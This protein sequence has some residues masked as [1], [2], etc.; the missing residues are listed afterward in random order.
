M[1]E[2]VPPPDTEGRR[3]ILGVHTRAMPLHEDVDLDELARRLERFTG[4]EIEGVCR[5]AAIFALRDNRDASTVVC[6]DRVHAFSLLTNVAVQCRKDFLRA[7]S[8]VKAATTDEMLE[9]YTAFQ[10]LMGTQH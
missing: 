1:L 4:A 3:A 5:E 2:Q 7:H 9:A 8:F 6:V 10:R